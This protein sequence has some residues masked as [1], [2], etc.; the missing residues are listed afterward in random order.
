[1]TSIIAQAEIHHMISLGLNCNENRNNV[2][3]SY[4][5]NRVKDLGIEEM[6]VPVVDKHGD[7][8]QIHMLGLPWL[9]L[10]PE[11]KYEGE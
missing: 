3:L 11:F 9:F 8:H 6:T 5:E 7:T 10:K 4:F 2:A 1:M